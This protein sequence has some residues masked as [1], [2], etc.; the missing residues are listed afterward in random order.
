MPNMEQPTALMTT[1]QLRP[2]L[3]MTSQLAAT[4]AASV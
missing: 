2:D 3:D 1:P 4:P